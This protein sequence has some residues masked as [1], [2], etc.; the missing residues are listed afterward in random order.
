MCPK[1]SKTQTKKSE[2]QQS[3]EE[4][5][6]QIKA[7]AYEL[8]EKRGCCHGG[9]CEDWYEAERIVKENGKKT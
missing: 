8:F 9:H 4:L 5:H 2:Q 6:E 1:R 7:K 3:G